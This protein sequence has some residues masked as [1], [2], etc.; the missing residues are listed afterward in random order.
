[1][2]RRFYVASVFLVL[3]AVLALPAQAGLSYCS[4]DPI[5]RVGEELVDVLVEIRAPPELLAQVTQRQP[6]KV[7]LM[8][9]KGTDPEV[10]EINGAFT[11]KA[12][13][14]EHNRGDFVI[15]VIEV[16]KRIA[17]NREYR[18]RVRITRN[19][20]TVARTMTRKATATLRFDW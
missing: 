15:V 2:I 4:A 6:V 9:P 20:H 5:F 17:Q 16:P 7:R 3:M 10:V 11:E 19:G 1:M 12:Y 8:S 18:L 13:C 14:R